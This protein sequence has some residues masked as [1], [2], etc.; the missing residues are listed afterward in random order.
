MRYFIIFYASQYFI[1]M[2]G[3]QSELKRSFPS[4]EIFDAISEVFPDKGSGEKLKHKL[5]FNAGLNCI[6]T[7]FFHN[8]NKAL[9]YNPMF[10]HNKE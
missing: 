7:T 2:D 4:D 5:V 9:M 3:C 6:R 1:G 10:Y 8:V